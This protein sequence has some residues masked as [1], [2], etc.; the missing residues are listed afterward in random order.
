M[1]KA[2]LE[3]LSMSLALTP[4]KVVGGSA[5]SRSAGLN[6]EMAAKGDRLGLVCRC[7]NV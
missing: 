6:D 4:N 2:T 1:G 3:Y 7:F 5:V